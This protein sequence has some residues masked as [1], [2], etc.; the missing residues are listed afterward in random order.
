MP[1]TAP[2]ETD[3]IYLL[4]QTI[5]YLPG[6]AALLDLRSGLS[7]ATPLASNHSWRQQYG[8]R[9]RALWDGIQ[10]RDRLRLLRQLRRSQTVA[11]PLQLESGDWVTLTILN[12]PR[13]VLSLGIVALQ[14]EILSNSRENPPAA[15]SGFCEDLALVVDTLPVLY[16][17]SG[18]D[19]RI[20]AVNQVYSRRRARP[21]AQL[22]TLTVDDLTRQFRAHSL[23]P[24][25]LP[26]PQPNIPAADSDF[27]YGAWL[28]QFGQQGEQL[29]QVHNDDGST[30]I[31]IWRQRPIRAQDGSLLFCHW[32]GY[33][34]TPYVSLLD[35]R[36][37]LLNQLQIRNR[38]L[39]HRV[40]NNLALIGSLL[41]FQRLSHPE[42]GTVLASLQRQVEAIALLQPYLELEA[43]ERVPL[44]PYLRDLLAAVMARHPQLSLR[45]S[46]TTGNEAGPALVPT[47]L[48]P[49]GIVLQE[50]LEATGDRGGDCAV[51]LETGAGELC[52]RL[53][54]SADSP[55]APIA[56]CCSRLLEGLM[57][58]LQAR[59]EWLHTREVQLR[60]PLLPSEDR[61][62]V[63]A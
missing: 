27:C 52:L 35:T 3:L 26:V 14:L 1:D 17:R 31:E 10:R 46:L 8:D 6:A 48:V 23:D 51:S 15:T 44:L 38:E 56:P 45:L 30:S 40:R 2:L 47:R 62:P 57:T 37:R 22:M 9:L 19:G 49:L 29:L 59:L 41:S 16:L 34:I 55:Q 42:A 33:D 21:M 28:N 18:N 43:S 50:L 61:E 12:R 63:S 13:E 24:G 5:E 7:H 39:M 54:F 36:G 20:L 25:Q 4:T 60:L 11:L 32:L 53:Q 58:Q